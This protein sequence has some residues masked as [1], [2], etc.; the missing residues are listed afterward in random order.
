MLWLKTV[1]QTVICY[2]GGRCMF[3][4]NASCLLGIYSNG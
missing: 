1:L 3:C 2:R 4:D